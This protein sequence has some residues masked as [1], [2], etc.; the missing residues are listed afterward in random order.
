MPF[1]KIAPSCMPATGSRCA[2]AIASKRYSVHASRLLVAWVHGRM[3]WRPG[4]LQPRLP[5]SKAR[6]L[7]SLSAG[8]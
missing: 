4:W 5:C 3:A 6:M 2:S 8:L 7:L 1:C